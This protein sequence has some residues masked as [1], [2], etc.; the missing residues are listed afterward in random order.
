MD[1]SIEEIK[2]DNTGVCN[3]CSMHDELD[4]KYPLN[5]GGKEKFNALINKI[6]RDGENKEYDCIV[7]V[8]GGRDSSYTLYTAVKMGLRPLAV[9][10]DNGWNSEIAAA[11][12][13]TATSTLDTDLHTIV[14]DWEEFKDLQLSFL[15][16]SVSDAEVPTDYVLTSVLFQEAA[17]FNVRY[18]LNGH[19][20]RTEGISPLSWTYMDGKYLKSIHQKFGKNPITSFPIMSLT[21]LLYYVLIRKIQFIHIPEYIPYNQTDVG[22]VLENELGW[23]YYGG[24]HHE[25]IYTEFFQSYYLPKKFNI[26]KRKTEFSALIRSGQMKREYALEEIKKPYQYREDLITYIMSKMGLNQQEFDEIISAPP[27]SF[28]DYPSYYPIIRMMKYP[29][30]VACKCDLLPQVFYEKY[31]N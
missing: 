3:F 12:I 5:T 11:N 20:F 7:G 27:K 21:Q 17:K 24:H 9:H 4:Q 16:A 18:I 31:I 10:F 29:I 22:K 26:D 19:S 15:K 25:N 6:K 14:A 8:S 23:K 2:F 1:S 13:K 30:W 28:H